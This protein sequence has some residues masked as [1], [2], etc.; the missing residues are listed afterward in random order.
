MGAMFSVGEIIVCINASGLPEQWL[1]LTVGNMYIVREVES[2]GDIVPPSAR[3]EA[4]YLVRLEGLVNII[5]PQFSKELGYTET[6]FD[7][8]RPKANLMPRDHRVEVTA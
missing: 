5:H 6:R 7:K 3:N 1:P 4:K 2:T 8:I